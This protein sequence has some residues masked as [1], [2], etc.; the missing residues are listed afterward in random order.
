[1]T[2]IKTKIDPRIEN[3]YKEKKNIYISL[4]NILINVILSFFF[5]QGNLYVPVQRIT[6][7]PSCPECKDKALEPEVCQ[8][9]LPK[10]QR[11]K[12]PLKPRYSKRSAQETSNTVFHKLDAIP[13]LRY[14][15]RI[16]LQIDTRRNTSLYS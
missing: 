7:Q 11:S 14:S 16:R 13:S 3:F 1:M 5:F 9:D 10:V 2:R 8:Y 6:Q 15:L 4:I 12:R